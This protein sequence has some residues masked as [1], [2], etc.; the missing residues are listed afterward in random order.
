MYCIVFGVTLS[1]LGRRGAVVIEFFMVINTVTQNMIKLV[2]WYSPL[3]IL[4]LITGQIMSTSDMTETGQTLAIYIATEMAGLAIHSLVVLPF[5]YFILTRKNPYTIY[6]K[7]I[8]ALL[9][10]FATSSSAA[11]LPVTMQCVEQRMKMD[12]RISRFILPVG[13]TVNMDGGAVFAAIAPMFIAQYN[14]ISLSFGDVIIVGDRFRTMVNVVSD[15]LVVGVVSHYTKLPPRDTSET[16]SEP[17]REEREMLEHDLMKFLKFL[18][19]SILLVSTILAVV[20]GI[21]AGILCRS[22]KPSSE[23]IHLV[24]FP[25]ELF[26]RMLK[27][28]MLPLIVASIITGLLMYCIVFGVTLGQLGRHGA[29]V[30]EFFAVINAVT[31]RMIRLVMCAATL[32]VTMQCVEERMKV[33]TRI[34]RFVLPVGATVNMDGGAVYAAIAPMFIAQYNGI[35]LSFG[36]VIIVRDRFRTT[37]NVAS[38]CLVVGVVSHYTKLPPR[39]TSETQ[40]EPLQEDQVM[41]ENDLV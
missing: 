41:L 16:Q 14:G 3:G 29:L 18:R 21:V 7:A 37:V 34:S 17:L 32:P 13:A 23:A 20:L 28:L 30:T 10:A 33:D 25:G 2:M 19:H 4:F 24:Q 35:S 27:L 40:T 38:D 6:L 15:C 31:L 1:H 36:N 12:T 8:Q 9:T 22:L 39:D 26:L 5:L 11:T